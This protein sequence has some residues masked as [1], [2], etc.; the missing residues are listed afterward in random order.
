MNESCYTCTY[1]LL[2]IFCILESESSEE[3]S[4][5]TS[6]LADIASYSSAETVFQASAYSATELKARYSSASL[7]ATHGLLQ[8][9]S[10][11]SEQPGRV[12]SP[13][14]TEPQNRVPTSSSQ[15]DDLIFSSQA[16][17]DLASPDSVLQA[18]RKRGLQIWK[19]LNNEGIGVRSLPDYHSERTG[20]V[21]C[22]LFRQFSESQFF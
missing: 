17:S 4:A 14:T 11:S 19:V 8:A 13:L 18:A 7:Q 5:V 10:V 6:N 3:E 22:A 12:E 2:Y 15:P 16:I 21:F 20:S 1:S 9:F